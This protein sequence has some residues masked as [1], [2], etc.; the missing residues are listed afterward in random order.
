MPNKEDTHLHLR[1]TTV[2]EQAPAR[3][4]PGLWPR[5]EAASRSTLV[6][7]R[8][9]PDGEVAF[10]GDPRRT[11]NFLDRASEAEKLERLGSCPRPSC[12]VG[13]RRVGIG[14]DRSSVSRYTEHRLRRP[15]PTRLDLR[16]GRDPR[17]TES[18]VLERTA[19]GGGTS[20]PL[21]IARCRSPRALRRGM[22][23]PTESWPRPRP[24]PPLSKLRCDQ[25][26]PDRLDEHFERVPYTASHWPASAPRSAIRTVRP[27]VS[28]C[29]H[30][31]MITPLV[32]SRRQSPGVTS[33][34]KKDVAVVV[35]TRNSAATLRLCLESIT[36]AAPPMHSGG[37]GQR[38]DRRHAAYCPGSG[39][40]R[41]RQRTRTICSAE[42]RRRGNGRRHR[43]VHRL[44][45][46]AASRSR[47]RSGQRHR[48]R[49]GVSRGA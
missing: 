22:K 3:C 45:H 21:P 1:R 23:S 36:S 34:E 38:I 31:V 13:P 16:V 14:R 11:S 30:L 5:P 39:R 2:V 29:S 6:D 40:R 46:G 17:G 27:F 8:H 18:S 33:F 4:A 7:T 9:R 28:T 25:T 12:D 47:E 15:G 37:G 20:P 32:D 24:L 48:R 19:R 49:C 26:G 43:R 10:A 42:C 41:A 44:R 35:P